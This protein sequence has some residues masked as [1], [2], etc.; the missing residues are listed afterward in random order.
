MVVIAIPTL[1]PG[2]FTKTA[3][4]L[5]EANNLLVVNVDEK[6]GKG[7]KRFD[8]YYKDEF[9]SLEK[10]EK[11]VK[12]KKVEVLLSGSEE[13]KEIANKLGLKFEKVGENLDVEEV[14]AKYMPEEEEEEGEEV[15]SVVDRIEITKEKFFSEEV[16]KKHKEL[17]EIESKYE[18]RE[19]DVDEEEEEEE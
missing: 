5:K 11:I 6:G 19:L 1:G 2:L 18:D 4:S 7:I 3:K 10:L 8:F 12:K 13:D 9:E 16:L 14:I 17:A 15:E